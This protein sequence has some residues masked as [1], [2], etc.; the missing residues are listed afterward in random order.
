MSAEAAEMPVNPS[1]PATIETKRKISAH[2]RIVIASSD[3]SVPPQA[4]LDHF[5]IANFATR[6]WFL[7]VPVGSDGWPKL[8]LLN[9]V[10]G[11]TVRFGE[12]AQPGR[13]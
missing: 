11:G 12:G 3:T 9:L 2:F 1:T 5:V 10:P 13:P 6:D 7:R 4:A 8:P